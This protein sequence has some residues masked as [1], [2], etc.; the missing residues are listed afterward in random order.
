MSR[1]KGLPGKY[2][3]FQIR[4]EIYGISIK[5]V[6]ELDSMIEV[7]PL[8]QAPV[9]VKG[10]INLRDKVVPVIDLRLRLG[11]EEREYTSETCVIIVNT[12]NGDEFGVLV[13]S[14][15]QVHDFAENQIEPSPA[16]WTKKNDSHFVIG[17]GKLENQIIILIDLSEALTSD[18]IETFIRDS[19]IPCKEKDIAK[20]ESQKLS[21]N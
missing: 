8:P 14:V 19:K 10:V 4:S 18:E 2:L 12:S 13:D 7:T 11:L 9:F 15:K 5:A 17:M 3:T 6:R 20:I 21:N 1:L 16:F